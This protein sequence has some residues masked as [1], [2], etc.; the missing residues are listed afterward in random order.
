MLLMAGFAIATDSFSDDFEDGVMPPWRPVTGLWMEADGSLRGQQDVEGPGVVAPM[1]H[2]DL[3]ETVVFSVQV[4]GTGTGGIVYLNGSESKWCAVWGG[5]GDIWVGNETTGP[6]LVVDG[7]DPGTPEE[8]TVQ[9]DAALLSVDLNGVAYTEPTDCN[10]TP[11]MGDAGVTALAGTGE[12]SFLEWSLTVGGPDSDGDG[13]IDD[14][15][16]APDDATISPEADEVWYDGVD[17]DCKGDDDYDQDYDGVLVDLDCDDTDAYVYPGAEDLWYDGRDSDC[18]GNDDFDA[19][20]D[21]HQVEGAGG[22]DCNDGDGTT[23]P[24]STADESDGLDHDCDGEATGG[25]D[26]GDDTD[27]GGDSGGDTDDTG[28]AGAGDCGC[29]TGA[30]GSVLAAGLGVGLALRRRR[31]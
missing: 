15:D 25:S 7:A 27:P 1:D 26:S 22:D 11:S 28:A 31:A 17:S 24:G 2:R 3:S 19:D 16:C 8:L 23:Y 13:V 14:L 29:G 10:A 20:G 6:V 30:P 4:T 21:G 12:V 9:V 5:H 18:A